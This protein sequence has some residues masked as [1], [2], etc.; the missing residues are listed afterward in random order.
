MLRT[1]CGILAPGGRIEPLPLAL[2]ACSLNHW[3]IRKFL[4]FLVFSI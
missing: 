2:E 4:I 3:P 1:V